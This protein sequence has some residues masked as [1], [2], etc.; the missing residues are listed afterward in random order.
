M[1]SAT[2]NRPPLMHSCAWRHRLGLTVGGAS[3]PSS[4]NECRSAS[5]MLNPG[6][7]PATFGCDSGAMNPRVA[8]SKS[9]GSS[10]GSASLSRELAAIVCSLASRRLSSL[11]LY[12][13]TVRDECRRLCE[14]DG[15]ERLGLVSEADDFYDE[16][17]PEREH[18]R[19]LLDDLD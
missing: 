8:C 5:Q 12:L 16:A 6:T 2:S 14:A 9:R 10:N 19:E 4:M 11:T 7:S 1:R 3:E 15:G 17:V 18:R 13:L